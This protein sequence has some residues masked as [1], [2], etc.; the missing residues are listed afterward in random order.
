MRA[1]IV[2]IVLGVALVIGGY[3]AN[4]YLGVFH[5]EDGGTVTVYWW[6]AYFVGGFEVLRGIV[7]AWRARRMLQ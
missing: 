5:T 7:M 6:A 2:H 3:L 4:T 1:G